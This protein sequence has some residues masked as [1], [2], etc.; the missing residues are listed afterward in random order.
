MKSQRKKEK[1][2]P[3]QA[4]DFLENFRKMNE[5]ID[6]PAKAISLRVPGNILNAFKTIAQS[7]K[8]GYQTMMIQA[9]RDYL[10]KND[11]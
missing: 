5:G 8:M 6:E 3:E 2:T 1:L 9:F 7:R 11:Y 4:L 10:K